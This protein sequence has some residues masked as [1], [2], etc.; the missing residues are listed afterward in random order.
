[1]KT[2]L[3]IAA[4]REGR[5]TEL[6]VQDVIKLLGDEKLSPMQLAEEIRQIA[7]V[8]FRHAFVNAENEQA[9]YLAGY[10]AIKPK[11]HVGEGLMNDYV[12]GIA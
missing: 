12:V 7:Q 6:I 11:L 3:Y 9:A 10:K 1:M 4:V 5:A 8:A 2:Y